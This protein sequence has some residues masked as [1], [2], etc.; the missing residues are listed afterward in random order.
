M[1]F[2]IICVHSVPARKAT[3]SIMAL[4]APLSEKDRNF[5]LNIKNDKIKILCYGQFAKRMQYLKLNIA[6]SAEVGARAAG[7]PHDVKSLFVRQPNRG[8]YLRSNI[9]SLA[10]C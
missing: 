6:V 10:R 5:V 3:N 1:P 9:S 4:S 2:A 7:R 8:K